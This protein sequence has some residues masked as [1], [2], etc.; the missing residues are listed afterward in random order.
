MRPWKIVSAG[1]VVAIAIAAAMLWPLLSAVPPDRIVPLLL[2][3]LPALLPSLI[4]VYALVVIVATVGGLIA[5]VL[6]LRRDLG[7]DG[8]A[9]QSAAALDWVAAFDATA[10]RALVPRPV[11]ALPQSARHGAT[12]LLATRFER[13]AARTEA[14]HLYY[15][16]LART[17]ALGA[18]VALAAIAALG[19]VQ[20]QGWAPFVPMPIATGTVIAV[21]GGLLLLAVIGR[22]ALD[23]MIEPLLEAMSRLP[24]EPVDVGWLRYAV[25]LLETTRIDAVSAG[26]SVAG[27]PSEVPDRLA[28]ALADGNRTLS[29]AGER[30]V[31][32]ADAIAAAARSSSGALDRVL[33]RLESIAAGAAEGGSAGTAALHRAVEALTAELRRVAVAE[34]AGAGIDDERRALVGATQRLSAAADAIGAA[35]RSSGEALKAAV[36]EVAAASATAPAAAA[37]SEALR[38]AVEALTEEFS[39]VATAERAGPGLE[40]ERR[41]LAA[42]TERL[43]AAADAIGVASRAAGETL[44]ARLSEAVAALPA[45]VSGGVEPQ[46]P[47]LQAA[48]EALTEELRRV[49]VADPT[50]SGLEAERRALAAATE[51]L[52]AAADALAAA[53]RAAGE[54]LAARVGEAVAALPAA[55]AGGAET[56]GAALRMSVEALTEEL[57]QFAALVGAA[58]DSAPSAEA[59]ANVGRELR[60]LLERI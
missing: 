18:L 46:S 53:S 9:G 29:L 22:F 37:T 16:W 1:A 10:L 35:A 5:A 33:R 31:A 43:S 13:H 56:Q 42:A 52:S 11:G 40:A 12:I 32:A 38:A 27:I 14:A 49:A 57:R 30:L 25:D 20:A 17:H 7:G 34:R 3:G 55:A 15:F 28:A 50:G 59:A 48:V 4:G 47:A 60:R 36:A 39:R 26:R 19:F 45:T 58:R 2:S 24:W 44:A 8:G 21:L 23:V 51:R 6:G 54:T 41:A